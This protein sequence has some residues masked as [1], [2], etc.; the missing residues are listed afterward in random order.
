MEGNTF[1]KLLIDQPVYLINAKSEVAST[2]TVKE[3]K[4]ATKEERAIEKKVIVLYP[5][6]TEK[7][8]AFLNKIL[9]AVKIDPSEQK[10]IITKEPD[11]PSTFQSNRVLF[12]GY[13]FPNKALYKIEQNNQRM[14]MYCD[15]LEDIEQDV[16]LKKMLWA[17]LQ[18]MFE[19]K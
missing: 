4:T 18:K 10:K 11:V 17:S 3:E 14:E 9:S 15:K 7:E 5:Q 13:P 8:I 19:E 6:A 16:S 1:L 2:T 12:F